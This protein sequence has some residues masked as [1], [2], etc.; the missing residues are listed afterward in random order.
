MSNLSKVPF[1]VLL[2]AF[3]IQAAAIEGKSM[4]AQDGSAS[5]EQSRSFLRRRNDLSSDSAGTAKRRLREGTV[6]SDQNGYFREDGDG[7]TFVSDE[8]WE[9]GALPNLNLERVVRQ[10]KNAEEPSSI[11]W[12]VSGLVTEFS[13]RNFL[14]VSR[15]VYKSA[16][17]PPLPDRVVK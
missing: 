5:R 15:A 8:G 14:L 9:F 16:T 7:A 12:N 6:I 17:P 13:G 10:L 4:V 1:G 3:V 2:V 11:R